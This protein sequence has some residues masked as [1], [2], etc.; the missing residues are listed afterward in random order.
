MDPANYRIG[1]GTM[2][3][4]SYSTEAT[5]TPD[6]LS[7]PLSKPSRLR[8]RLN[9]KLG[10]KSKS[11]PKTLSN[12]EEQDPA[13]NLHKLPTELLLLIAQ[14]LPQSSIACLAFT[15][16]T[17]YSVFDHKLITNIKSQNLTEYKILLNLLSL[18][19]PYLTNCKTC[20]S[21][22][23]T[24]IPIPTIESKLA[25]GK[26]TDPHRFSVFDNVP[27]TE[28]LMHL[29]APHHKHSRNR[30]TTFKLLNAHIQLAL[31]RTHRLPGQEHNLGL[32]VHDLHAHG[33]QVLK[34]PSQTAKDVKPGYVPGSPFTATYHWSSESRIVEGDFLHLQTCRI[35][36]STDIVNP[37]GEIQYT[38]LRR[39]LACIDLRCC[40]HC[41]QSHPTAE[42]ICKL[43]QWYKGTVNCVSADKQPEYMC[44]EH[45]HSGCR[46]TVD[47]EVGVKGVGGLELGEGLKGSQKLTDLVVR[48]WRLIGRGPVKD[49]WVTAR[50]G[51][52]KEVW[53]GT[54]F[55]W[56][57]GF[58]VSG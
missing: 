39:A 55:G 42:V 49:G 13:R 6:S 4:A 11:A 16:P 27:L 22:H 24:R 52:V 44:G 54:G 51:M 8:Q 41:K 58:P 36:L 37:V 3:L 1:K 12:V 14:Y 19:K 20:I 32:C 2:S 33:T 15:H 17:I 47:F 10:F 50:R 53:E 5:L 56:R 28:T 38:N 25:T 18:D 29:R 9:L 21:L 57:V 7:K 35:V 31:L 43:N 48:T 23:D 46:C 26:Y 45:V 34:F 30:K 40:P